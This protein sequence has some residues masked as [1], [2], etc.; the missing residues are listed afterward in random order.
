M[1]A[2]FITQVLLLTVFSSL[3][4]QT[5]VSAS[6]VVF[7]SLNVGTHCVH[8]VAQLVNFSVQSLNVRRQLIDLALLEQP[9]S[10]VEPR[11]TAPSTSL[12]RFIINTL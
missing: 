8:V 2:I 1:C 11:I 10:R 4:V 9:A 7:S 12:V 3:V 5:L 6:C